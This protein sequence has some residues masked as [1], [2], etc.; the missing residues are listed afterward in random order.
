[1]AERGPIGVCAPEATLAGVQAAG[2]PVGTVVASA[3]ALAGGWPG[4][5]AVG[6]AVGPGHRRGPRLGQCPPP[7]YPAGLGGRV[8]RAGYGR[9][10][11]GAAG[12]GAH[13]SIGGGLVGW[14]WCIDS[15]YS[16]CA[17]C[18]GFDESVFFHK[19]CNRLVGVFFVGGGEDFREC[20]DA[21]CSPTTGCRFE[22]VGNADWSDRDP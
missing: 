12:L 1:M 11:A 20:R 4:G 18:A 5:F 17:F 3:G 16:C 14:V 7:A 10:Q 22:L 8:G 9:P 15:H 21:F 13:G 2:Y 6:L 19:C